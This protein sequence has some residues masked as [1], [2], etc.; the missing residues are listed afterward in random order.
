MLRISSSVLF[1]SSCV[2]LLS[3]GSVPPPNVDSNFKGVQ[4]CLHNMDCS[5]AGDVCCKSHTCCNYEDYQ[6]HMNKCSTGGTSLGCGK[7]SSLV[8]C[9]KDSLCR[10]THDCPSHE[11]FIA[12][13]HL[14]HYM[15]TSFTLHGTVQFASLLT[16][17][18]TSN[19]SRRLPTFF[20]DLETCCQDSSKIL[21]RLANILPRS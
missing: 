18:N 1:V 8:C 16:S 19:I 3:G 4:L 13:L 14:M 5:R 2:A 6:H 12:N 20:Q 11:N 10:F 7:D 21:R 9:S 17:C 15:V